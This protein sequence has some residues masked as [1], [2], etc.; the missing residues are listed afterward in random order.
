MYAQEITR[1]RG[2]RNSAVGTPNLAAESKPVNSAVGT[3][4]NSAE[5]TLGSPPP[6]MP[7]MKEAKVAEIAEGPSQSPQRRQSCGRAKESPGYNTAPS[8]GYHP[9]GPEYNQVE[10]PVGSPGYNPGGSTGCKSPGHDSPGCY[11]GLGFGSPGNNP[12][13]STCSGSPVTDSPGYILGGSPGYN[14]GGSKCSGSPVTNSPGYIL[15]Q[16]CGSPGGIQMKIHAFDLADP[17]GP[18]V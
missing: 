11:P 18:N 9:A 14:P 10:N 13:C 1:G 3:P 17:A 8:P 16:G 4:V 5:D 2:A 7:A 6:I 12:G 15:G